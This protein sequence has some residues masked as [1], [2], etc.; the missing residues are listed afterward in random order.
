MGTGTSDPTLPL[1]EGAGTLTRG[2]PPN[3]ILK[4]IDC[5]LVILIIEI[6]KLL[7]VEQHFFACYVCVMKGI[8]N[9]TSGTY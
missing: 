8:D 9:W 6:L 4:K 1:L 3:I 5:I 7:A 2:K